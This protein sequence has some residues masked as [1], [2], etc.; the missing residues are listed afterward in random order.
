MAGAVCA[1][2]R[3]W[4][5]SSGR[6][7]NCATELLDAW[8]DQGQGDRSCLTGSR[9]RW[10]YAQLQA[11]ANRI[12]HVLVQ[13]M[14]VQPGNRVLLRGGNSPMLAAC[15]FALQKAGAIAEATMPLLRAK[16]LGQIIDKA[17]VSHALCDDGL[18]EELMQAQAAHPVL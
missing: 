1:A 12:A 5:R 8:V 10:T 2:G 13:D 4:N 9:H 6:S 14:G 15:W 11:E 3:S 18:A 7:R 16:E 17:Q